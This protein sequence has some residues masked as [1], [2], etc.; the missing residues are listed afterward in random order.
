VIRPIAAG[1]GITAAAAAVALAQQVPSQPVFRAGVDAIMV[2]VSVQTSD[3]PVSGLTAADFRLRDN[4]IL[5]EIVVSTIDAVP[6]DVTVLVDTSYSV[7]PNLDKFRA[8]VQK[9]PPLLRPIDRV[10][11]VAFA[12]GATEILPM[13]PRPKIIAGDQI[14]PAG[15]TSL[16]DALLFALVPEPQP[17]RRHLVILL[18]DGADSTSAIDAVDVP[19]IA[20]RSGAILHVVLRKGPETA[21]KPTPES[22]QAIQQAAAQTG[23]RVWDLSTTGDIVG[24]L[25]QVFE[26]FKQNYVLSFVPKGVSRDGWHELSVDLPGLPGATVV[27]RKGY[28]GG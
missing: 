5:Q 17:G 9:F 7:V 18:T 14:K 4:G 8:D 3:R 26:H 1:F 19:G 25:T 10:R 22:E 24:V 2:D 12:Y 23:G 21:G 20:T 6:V 15:G 27:A 13:Q 28:F 16:N 11:L